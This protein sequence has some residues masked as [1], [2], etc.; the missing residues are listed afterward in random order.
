MP[1]ATG[2][3][4]SSRPAS[5]VVAATRSLASPW[6]AA[7]PPSATTP[8]AAHSAAGLFLLAVDDISHRPVGAH[9]LVFMASGDG[10]FLIG[11][12]DRMLTMDVNRIDE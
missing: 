10:R 5:R 11:S 12:L 4:P 1:T 3:C 9:P 6:R 8:S 2:S 7:S